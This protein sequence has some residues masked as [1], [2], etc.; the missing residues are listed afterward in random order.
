[1][2]VG[3]RPG[4]EGMSEGE[5]AGDSVQGMRHVLSAWHGGITFTRLFV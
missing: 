5:E 3:A 2:G 1:M 4:G